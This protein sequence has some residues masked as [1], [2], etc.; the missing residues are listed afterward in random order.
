[1]DA[2]V[3]AGGAAAW[4]ATELLKPE[5]APRACQW[6]EVNSLDM[7]VRRAVVWRDAGTADSLSSLTA[8]FLIP[9]AAVGLDAVAASHEGAGSNVPEDALLVAEAG[10]IAADVNQIAKL[11]FG[12]ERPYAYALSR[13]PDASQLRPHTPD[14]DLSFFSGHTTEAFAL[15]AASGT[16]AELRGY[17]WAP[18]TW[19]V[20]A[21][22][23]AATAYLRIAADRHWLTD[24]LVGAVVGAG[25]G[26][27]LPLLFH[28][29][30]NDAGQGSVSSALRAPPPPPGP[31]LTFTW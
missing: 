14:D 1:V 15:A 2:A 3:T 9:L 23:A 31:A 7:G 18:L 30:T 10:I 12:R 11:A 16:V 22:L 13:S 20:G 21:A 27:G 24:V 19:G 4:L 26:T 28:P 25:I 5:L 6:C 17:R 8:F 29:R